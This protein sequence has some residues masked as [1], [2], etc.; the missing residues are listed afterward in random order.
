V[1]GVSTETPLPQILDEARRLTATAVER[2]V[3]IRLVGGLAV[4]I[5][6]DDTFHPGLSRE[7]KDID[8]VTLKGRSKPVGRFLEEMGYEP[9]EQFNAM[10]GSERLLFYDM[11]NE[12]QLDV[13]VGAFRMC[14]A[15]PITERITLDP[16]TLP[17]AELLL[18]KL[19]IVHLN[20]KDLRDLMAILHHHDVADEDGDTINAAYVA[21]LCAEDWGLWRTTKMNVD[22]VRERVEDYDLAAHERETVTQRLDRLWARIEA[23]PKSRGWRMRDRI[24]DR[25][26]WYDE[27]EEVG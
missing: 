24:G 11:A 16:L 12:R 20:E 27:P 14:H 18:T 3:P 26:R 15:I 6:V 5:R 9:A 8:L 10:N 2:D 13:F 22:R 7:Y 23:E 1:I 17:L 4:R 19:Q 21:R 25:K